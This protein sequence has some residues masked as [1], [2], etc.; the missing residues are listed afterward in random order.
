MTPRSG[1]S[2]AI[3]SVTSSSSRFARITGRPSSSAT[4]ATGEGVSTRLRPTGASARV[5]T[6]TTSCG[7][8]ARARRVGTAAAGVPAKTRRTGFSWGVGEG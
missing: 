5:T 7:E 3:R 4:T 2:V 1:A 8:A 6:A